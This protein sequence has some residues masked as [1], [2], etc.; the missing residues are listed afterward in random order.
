M[1]VFGVILVLIFLHLDWYSVRMR[2]NTDQKNSEYEHFSLSKM[3]L[4][5]IRHC[6]WRSEDHCRSTFWKALYK[7]KKYI[8]YHYTQPTLN[9]LFKFV[10]F[11]IFISII[12]VSKTILQKK[13]PSS[14]CTTFPRKWEK[15]HTPNGHMANRT[16]W[17]E[18][19]HLDTFGQF[20][21]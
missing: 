9:M 4:E 7:A 1:S 2:E 13:R 6:I 14:Q 18:F 21:L 10:D 20:C 3:R 15:S 8:C 16:K 11:K 12:I 5:K 19:Y 17:T